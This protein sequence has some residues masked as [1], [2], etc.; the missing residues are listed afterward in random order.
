VF[1]AALIHRKSDC[2]HSVRLGDGV[3]EQWRAIRFWTQQGSLV[4]DERDEPVFR[5]YISE[6]VAETPAARPGA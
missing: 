1:W 5:S 2:I 4:A 3:L 6:W